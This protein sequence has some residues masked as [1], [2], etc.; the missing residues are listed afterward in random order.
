VLSAIL[1]LI[2]FCKIRNSFVARFSAGPLPA[3]SIADKRI[4]LLH[5]EIY[6]IYC[7]RGFF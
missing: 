5:L 2:V 7:R 6:G 3:R 1:T 4:N